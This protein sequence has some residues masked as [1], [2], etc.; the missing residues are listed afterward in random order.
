MRRR[1]ARC[2][3]LAGSATGS[4][5][6]TL[7]EALTA[8]AI[9]SF[10]CTAV[11]LSMT[12]SLMH[13]E[14]QTDGT[15]AIRLAQDMLQEISSK[16]FYDPD[17][18]PVFGIEPDEQAANP[19]LQRRWVFDD[20]DDYDGWDRQSPEDPDGVLLGTEVDGTADARALARYAEF[21]RRVHVT[22]VKLDDHKTPAPDYWQPGVDPLLVHVTVEIEYRG[23]VVCKLQKL[24]SANELY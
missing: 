8:T 16:R 4:R 11:L 1:H 22:Y 15:L 5:G 10:A 17:P 20:I 12:G 7:T 9:A 18:S 6:F 13:V 24:F 3:R 14:H 19:D 21:R 2:R 23:R